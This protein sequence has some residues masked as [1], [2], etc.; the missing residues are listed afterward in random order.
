MKQLEVCVIGGTGNISAP[1]V[2]SL[3]SAGFHLTC[4]NRGMTAFAPAGVAHVKCDRQD[5]AA[6]EDA[7]RSRSFH[8]VIDMVSFTAEDARS[9]IRACQGVSHFIQISTV[10]TYGVGFDSF[11]VAEDHQLRPITEYGRNKAEAD[12]V[13]LQEFA[14]QGY[15]VTIVKPSTTYGPVQGLLR[16]LG[17][18][19]SWV[20]RV[21]AG[22]P[23]LVV[24]G[25]KARHQ[26]LHVTDA[27]RGLAAMV[28]RDD[29]AGEVI[30]LVSP[31]LV[32][33]ADHHK[34]L[35]TLLDR[36]VPLV[37]AN[38]KQLEQGGVPDL[39]LC[40]TIFSHDMHY[41]GSKMSALFPDVEFTV[42]LEEGIRSVLSVMD[43]DGR[44]PA[45]MGNGWEDSLIS[46]METG[47]C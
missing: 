17:R 25:G 21:R 33:W 4:L 11:P 14:R 7:I 18:D 28:G 45:G 10:C 31:E 20:D 42:S 38:L 19:F 27:A 16:Q 44:L 2:A 3:Q 8:T 5:R 12:E 30:N 22:K 40:K 37:S 36:E 24:E 29:L 47:G 46:A 1:L 13:L 32:T 34:T 6:F 35:M 9:A 41:D 39:E 26:F 43:Q 23:I 15:P